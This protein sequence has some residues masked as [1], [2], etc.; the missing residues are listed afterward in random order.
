MSAVRAPAVA[1]SF[2]PYAAAELQAQLDGLLSSTPSTEPAMPKALIVPH[3]GYI[4][5]GS[6]AASAYAALRPFRDKIERVVLLGPTHRVAVRGLALPASDA[7]ATPLGLVAVD[8]N[9]ATA[10]RAM[11]QVCTSEQV[12]ALEHSLE[13]HLPFLQRVLHRFKLVPLAVGDASTEDVAQVLNALWGGE[14]TLIIVSSDL[15]HYLPYEQA[16]RV[17]EQTAGMVLGLSP[18][19]DHQRA[20]GAT[21]INGLLRVAGERGLRPQLLDLRNSGDTAGDR[22]RVV[23]YA[24][25]AFYPA[26]VRVQQE[27]CT[28]DSAI[29]GKLLVPIARASIASQ[30]GLHF[31]VRA[32]AAFLHEPGASFVTLK[33]NGELRGC[34]GSLTANRNL[35]DDVRANACAAAFKDPRFAPLRLDEFGSIRVEVSLLSALEPMS[36]KTEADALEQMRP[37]VD[38]MMLEFGAHRGTFL[39]QVWENLAEP[40]SFL[41]QLKRKA[42]LPVD[43]WDT[44][45]QLSRYTVTKWSESSS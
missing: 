7:F 22:N 1:G 18:Q 36:F 15:S 20:C 24:S 10:L 38:G 9:A 39:P 16:R 44:G 19:L 4:Y 28:A 5:S 6:I 29:D 14:E 17:D 2:Y 34:I 43:F 41:G 12:H 3:A 32:S 40:Q 11:T 21:P 35:V 25:F 13:V 42:G 37:G 27:S 26:A 8:T 45:V 31:S 30:F 23:G 33:S